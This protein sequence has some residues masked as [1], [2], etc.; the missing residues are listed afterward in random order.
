[1]HAD[2]V[3]LGDPFL[4]FFLLDPIKLAGP[5]AAIICKAF[6]TIRIGIGLLVGHIGRI[7]LRTAFGI[8]RV[9]GR[10]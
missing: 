6:L 10:S 8:V 3:V 2:N 5:I 9:S 4:R 1:M 7:P